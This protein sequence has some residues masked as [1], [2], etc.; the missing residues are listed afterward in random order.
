[1][2]I[3]FFVSAAIIFYAYLGYPLLLSVLSAQ[4]KES[5]PVSPT[6]FE[7]EQLPEVTVVMAVYN[8]E[9]RIISRL[10]NLIATS[11]PLDKLHIIVVSDGST[12][13]TV[14]ITKSFAFERL[15]VIEQQNNQGKSV[16]INIAL[17]KVTTPLVAFADLRQDFEQDALLE[18]SRFFKNY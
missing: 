5:I 8:G 10:D 3:I 17:S 11:F 7:E 14:S 13:N 12:D 15:T 2:D 18:M 16:A 9:N 6:D 4:K 1:M